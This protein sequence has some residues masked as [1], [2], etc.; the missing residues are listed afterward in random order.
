[1]DYKKYIREVPD[2]PKKGILFYDVT[3]L[4]SDPKVFKTITDD[5]YE[6]AKS[7]NITKV[8]AIEARG[9]IFGAPLAQKLNVP[10]IPIRKPGKLPYKT[11]RFE[12]TLEYGKDAV[13]IHEDAVTKGDKI[14]MVD[15]LLATGGTISAAAN[16]VKECGGEVSG[17]LFVI[18]LD[19]LKGREKLKD[20]KVQS[21][22][23]YD[24]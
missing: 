4:L 22:V 10:F 17:M 13:E 5:M 12:Y 8:A 24:S 3:T 23:R 20:Y 15:D 19:F 18:E 9:F 7:L 14:L 2:F 21:L 6:R 11:K 16:L 1:M